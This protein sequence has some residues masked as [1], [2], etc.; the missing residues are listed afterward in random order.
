MNIMKNLLP[1]LALL[2][3][4]GCTSDLDRCIEANSETLTV[5]D[6]ITSSYEFEQC[7]REPEADYSRGDITFKTFEVKY[8]ECVSSSE[9]MVCLMSDVT[10]GNCYG[11]NEKGR[12]ELVEIESKKICNAQGI[13]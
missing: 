12:K 7:T 10:P 13:Y 8:K 9:Y 6:I 1:L 2:L 3:L 4:V 11:G 5:R